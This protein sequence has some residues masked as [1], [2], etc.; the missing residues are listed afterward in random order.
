[1]L[2]DKLELESKYRRPQRA[3]QLRHGSTVAFHFLPDR[4]Q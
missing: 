4:T 3:S 1:L 2:T